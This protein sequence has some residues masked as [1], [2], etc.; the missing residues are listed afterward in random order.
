[1]SQDTKHNVADAFS[2]VHLSQLSRSLQ[3]L[4]TI[5]PPIS[6]IVFPLIGMVT[7]LLGEVNFNIL[8]SSSSHSQGV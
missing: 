6:T 8:T 3:P 7:P 5:P 1:M 4:Y 2:S